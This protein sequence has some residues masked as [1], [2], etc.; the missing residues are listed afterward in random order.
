[1]GSTISQKDC[2]DSNMPLET[3]VKDLA[4][5]LGADLV[6]IASPDSIHLKDNKASIE[7]LLPGCRSLIVVAKRLNRDAISSG[8]TK[9]A[10]Y[11]TLCTYQELDRVIYRI[12]SHLN[13]MGFR[14]VAIPP[15]M[16]ID[17]GPET[18]GMYGEVNQKCAATA[19]GLGN[20]GISRLF[21]C[22]EF[23]PFVRMGSILATADLRP[24]EPLKEDV[25]TK[26]LECVRRCP[27]GALGED[28][29]LDIGKCMKVSLL[30]GLPGVV[31]FGMKAVGLDDEELRAHIGS[32]ALWE[33]W[34]NLLIGNFNNC[35]ECI[36]ACPRRMKR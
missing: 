29:S 17:F 15:N 2:D 11:D 4:R 1:M 22:P 35:F 12:T 32:P 31:R 34:Q 25:C 7:A 27:A 28:G 10:Q 23:G 16:P 26:C 14:A 20:I 19:A 18:R 21:L 8:N 5:S 9:I 24:D 30:Y 33:L 3:E 36:N 6:G 13:E